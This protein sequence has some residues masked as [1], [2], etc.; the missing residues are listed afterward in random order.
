MFQQQDAVTSIDKWTVNTSAV[1]DMYYMFCNCENLTSIDVTNFDT[2]NVIYMSYMFD[3]CRDLTSVTGF[4]GKDMSSCTSMDSMFSQCYDLKTI[5]FS[6]ADLSSVT[7]M[8]NMF[9]AEGGRLKTAD[10]SGC[11]LSKVTD[12]HNMFAFQTNLTAVAF[13][14]Y[15]KNVQNADSAFLNCS[16]LT[17][18]HNI[19]F[20]GDSVNISRLCGNTS[21]GSIVSKLGDY[22]FIDG[23]TITSMDYAFINQPN[24][25]IMNIHSAIGLTA[26]PT[27]AFKGCTGLK[28]L[29]MSQE[30]EYILA[31]LQTDLPDYDWK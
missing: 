1:T 26:A 13:G 5:D 17:S 27:Q 6:G 24:I 18:F 31:A 10:F 30:N 25:E 12:I 9:S 16:S 14:Y 20:A 21:T 7:D 22:V 15:M 4:A 3:N 8:N 29:F 11:D 28:L 23:G 2:S 19:G